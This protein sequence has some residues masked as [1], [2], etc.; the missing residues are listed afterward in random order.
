MTTLYLTSHVYMHVYQE[1]AKYPLFPIII[2]ANLSSSIL[3]VDQSGT[4][5]SR[6][7][8][9]AFHAQGTTR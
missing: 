6:K 2:S 5:L 7:L 9:L 4:M 1:P 3:L 8:F